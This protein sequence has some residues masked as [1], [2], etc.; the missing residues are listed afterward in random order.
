MRPVQWVIEGSNDG[1]VDHRNTPD[2]NGCWLVH[3]HSCVV[4]DKNENFRFIRLRRAG[5]DTRGT[6]SLAFAEASFRRFQSFQTHFLR[7]LRVHGVAVWK[8]SLAFGSQT[9]EVMIGV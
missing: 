5:K 9:S 2:L 4:G 7:E 1:E 6:D 8:A 3:T